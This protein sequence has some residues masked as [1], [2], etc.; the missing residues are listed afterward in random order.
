VG[1]LELGID[2]DKDV[3]VRRGLRKGGWLAVSSQLVSC[4]YGSI[5]RFVH[6]LGTRASLSLASLL[7]CMPPAYLLPVH[8]VVAYS[9]HYRHSHH[10]ISRDARMSTGAKVAGVTGVTSATK[11][12]KHIDMLQEI[13][14]IMWL[15]TTGCE[16]VCL[17]T[18]ATDGVQL[19]PRRKSNIQN[20]GHWTRLQRTKT[21]A[22]LRQAC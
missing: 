5:A 11:A 9:H 8:L 6:D 7:V 13:C 2:S 20:N 21:S 3:D 18:F 14:N 15:T 19:S 1:R 12:S 22:T 10:N 17:T 4:V 16:F